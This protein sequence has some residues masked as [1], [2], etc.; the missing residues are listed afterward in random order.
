MCRGGPPPGCEVGGPARANWVSRLITERPATAG[1]RTSSTYPPRVPA[2]R[3][4]PWSDRPGPRSF[5]RPHST[6][7]GPHGPALEAERNVDPLGPSNRYGISDAVRA[8]RV[9]RACTGGDIRYAASV[10]PTASWAA[11]EGSLGLVWPRDGRAARHPVGP[12]RWC[13]SALWRP[14]HRLGGRLPLRPRVIGSGRYETSAGAAA[15]FLGL[16]VSASATIEYR[17]TPECS[18][19][20]AAAPSEYRRVMLIEGAASRFG[21]SAPSGGR[22][23][24]PVSPAAVA[25]GLRGTGRS[26]HRR[27]RSRSDVLWPTPPGGH[28]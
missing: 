16:A 18:P 24:R 9:E 6:S 3:T 13:R 22:A 14:P 19:S 2:P 28:H 26:R 21:R 17:P 10:E 25:S 7:D 11:R 23:L 15:R 4:Y 8:A 5:S 12:C 20:H 1:N 27:R